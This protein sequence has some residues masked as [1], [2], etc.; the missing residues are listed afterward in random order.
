MHETLFWKMCRLGDKQVRP[1]GHNNTMLSCSTEKTPPLQDICKGGLFYE[2]LTRRM[3]KCSTAL[4]GGESAQ[5]YKSGCPLVGTAA[6]CVCFTSGLKLKGPGGALSGGRRCFRI[7]SYLRCRRSF[8]AS[9]C[10]AQSGRPPVCS[11]R[12]PAGAGWGCTGGDQE[13]GAGRWQSLR[14]STC[15]LPQRREADFRRCR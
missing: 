13:C 7:H 2:M 9:C 10:S 15:R 14:C 1:P 11:P 12:V 8:R 6:F 5:E 3:S 4:G